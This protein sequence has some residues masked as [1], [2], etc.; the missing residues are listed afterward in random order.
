MNEQ[1]YK[2]MIKSCLRCS[3]C[4]WIPQLQIKSQKYAT[5]CPSIDMFNFHAYS[6][7]GRII[8]A[9]ALEMGRLK[10]SKE[11]TEI[12]YKCT[13]CGGCA[14][15]CKF[16]NTLEPLEIIVKL[17]EKLVSLGY[18]PMPTQQQYI[19]SIKNNNNPY[20]EAHEKRFDWLPN[21]I[22]TDPNSKVLYFVG[23]T[24]SYRRKEIA[25]ATARILNAANY[26]FK[27]LRENEFCC[28][29]PILRTG[30][31]ESFLNQV[32]KNLDIIDKKGIETVVFSCAGCYDTFKV[33]YP[34]ERKY[35][36][37]VLHTT[38]L[39]NE[40]IDTSKLELNN[41]VPYNVTYHDPCHLGRNSEPYEEWDG[42][43]LKMM[44]LVSIN[45]PA[46]P[47]R[48]GNYGIYD[49]PRK[50][51]E[52]IRGIDFIEMERIKE[53]AYCCGAGGGVKAAFPEFALNT[54]KTRI[55]EAEDTGAEIITSA[56][57]FCSSNLKDGINA[58]SS[59]LRF[60]DISELV[61]MA[62]GSPNKSSI[63]SSMEVS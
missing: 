54:A 41:Q 24:S 31:K 27:I 56:C 28:G 63:A 45:I 61:L 50:L 48:C 52:K 3:I 44:P 22:K 21:D 19:E 37:K 2:K 47:K 8:L 42:D 23:C 43:E 9:L 29:S 5:I 7:G 16:L 12:V 11:L 35:N 26:P 18:G 40:L 38:E 6:G 55:E 36:F 59:D 20:N 1:E 60:L 39:F 51:I 17:R 57:P 62:L 14:V 15:A 46:K 49:S 53:Y 4:K 58:K 10:P 32:D 33:D 34:L 25:V 30:D 13:E